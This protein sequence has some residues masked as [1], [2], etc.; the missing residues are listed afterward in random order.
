MTRE[1]ALDRTEGKLSMFLRGMYGVSCNAKLFNI[2]S[3]SNVLGWKQRWADGY[4][5]PGS[6]S[7]HLRY[8]QLLDWLS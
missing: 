3:A 6:A 7:R 4:Q 1:R 5:A 2:V 8:K